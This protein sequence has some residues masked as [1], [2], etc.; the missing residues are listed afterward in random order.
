VVDNLPLFPMGVVS[1]L[2]KVHP[3]T[4]R[5]WERYGIIKPQRRSGKRFYSEIDL[6]RLRFIKRLITD[7]LNL[8]AIRHYLRLYP[9]WQMDDCP[10]CMQVSKLIACAKPCWKEENVYC[11]V[12]GNEET[13]LNCE[14]Q[15]QHAAEIHSN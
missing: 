14:F 2:L 4:I 6:L 10:S 3:E 15:K 13:C 7:K 5:V 1:E 9:C 12:S 11:Q 8:P